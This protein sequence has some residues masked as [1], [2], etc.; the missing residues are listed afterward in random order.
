[1]D[2]LFLYPQELL[3]VAQGKNQTFIAGPD[4]L[5]EI[6]NAIGGEVRQSGEVQFPQRPQRSKFTP[7]IVGEPISACPPDFQLWQTS[8]ELDNVPV[9]ETVR[10][11]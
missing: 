8:G 7:N 9:I 5:N 3:R 11:P 4:L 1:M 2:Q 10:Y 6:K